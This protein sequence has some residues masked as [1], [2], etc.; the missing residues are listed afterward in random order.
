MLASNKGYIL[1]DKVKVGDCSMFKGNLLESHLG[2]IDSDL[3]SANARKRIFE[4]EDATK[5]L[6]SSENI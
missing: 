5:R 2:K 3:F 1:F 4:E 6:L